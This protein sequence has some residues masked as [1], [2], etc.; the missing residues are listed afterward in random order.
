MCR[1]IQGCAVQV[2]V[3]QRDQFFLSKIVLQVDG[4]AKGHVDFANSLVLL[5][6]DHAVHIPKT[7]VARVAAD[8]FI[9][10]VPDLEQ[11]IVVDRDGNQVHVFAISLK[12]GQ[13]G[14][15]DPLDADV[16]D[17][18]LRES[19]TAHPLVVL[20]HYEELF[21][22]QDLSDE[23]LSDVTFLHRLVP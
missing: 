5:L 2:F 19:A 18:R 17:S 8:D 20:E 10:Q 1:E 16:C 14:L 21:L 3:G 15:H 13:V 11:S 12:G 23:G 9:G 4:V 7:K 22:V 6:S